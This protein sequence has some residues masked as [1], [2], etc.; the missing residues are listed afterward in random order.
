MASPIL[1]RGRSRERLGRALLGNASNMHGRTPG[2]GSGAR[3]R[4][5]ACDDNPLISRL[6]SAVCQMEDL[7]FVGDASDGRTCVDLVRET[8]PD[9]LVLDMEMPGFDGLYAI[10]ELRRTSSDLK[11]VVY[12]GTCGEE[13]EERVVRAGADA[14]V[15]KGDPI[16]ELRQALRDL[17]GSPAAHAA[18]VAP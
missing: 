14:Y 16:E 18:G 13:V 8:A 2:A 6:V 5:A 1:A 9:L 3:P 10:E 7:E 11:V 17:A 4:V 12:S 15:R